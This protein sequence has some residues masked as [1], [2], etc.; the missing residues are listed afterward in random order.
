[1]NKY[2]HL[3][4]ELTP[5]LE[6]DEHR[7]PVVIGALITGEVVD[8]EADI[9]EVRLVGEYVKEAPYFSNQCS[10]TT[11]TNPITYITH[12]RNALST[13]TEHTAL[14]GRKATMTEHDSITALND[15]LKRASSELR[16]PGL[17]HK[18]QSMLGN[19]TFIGEKEYREAVAGIAD[20]WRTYLDHD[21]QTQLC[22]LVGLAE[23][24][25]VKSGKYLLDSILKEFSDEEL[26]KW[27]NRLV[28]SPQN[29]SADPKD[30]NI[31]L[32]DD[33]TI[34]GQQLAEE[35]AILHKEYPR[36]SDCM[37]IQLIT[38]TGERL[39]CGFEVYVNDE[40]QS[41]TSA[42]KMPISAYY[43]AHTA[44]EAES[45]AYTTGAHCATDI[46]FNDD[47]AEMATQLAVDM[48]PATNISRPYR[49]KDV[50][51]E[52]TS[53]LNQ[54]PIIDASHKTY[55][56][57]ETYTRDGSRAIHILIKQTPTQSAAE[58]WADYL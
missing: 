15:F 37:S 47:I 27:D 2:P 19:L 52:Q 51:L 54:E 26:Q 30:V 17:R 50:K 38:A 9:H 56:L 16:D 23:P 5:Y 35:A 8:S 22:P 21:L 7:T 42:L 12:A 14:E 45:G 11:R 57:A 13:A 25:A 46:D 36:Y 39:D 1:M 33:W 4:Q 20:T 49:Q 10:D 41:C 18:A 43:R 3:S 29:L 24:T 53:R 44:L 55:R 48:P 6:A 32:L 31:V 34:S 40:Q 58:E 28:T